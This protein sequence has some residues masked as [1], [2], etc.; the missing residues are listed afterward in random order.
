MPGVNLDFNGNPFLSPE[1]TNKE[2]LEVEKVQLWRDLKPG[3]KTQ[4]GDR[5]LTIRRQWETIKGVFTIDP[6]NLFA[7]RPEPTDW[8]ARA[9]AAEYRIERNETEIEEL[10]E[11]LSASQAEAG[12]LRAAL[13]IHEGKR[14]PVQGYAPGI[15][16]DMHMEA[17]AAYCVK[18]SPQPALIDLE[19]RHCRGGFATSELD[20][21]TPGWRDEIKRRQDMARMALSP[22]EKGGGE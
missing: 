14:A 15:P 7:Q 3:E 13:E 19:G 20:M 10:K 16:W 18:Y 17:Y 6:S 9:L 4:P 22:A 1:P 11:Q 8:Q 5:M 2:S 12:R 21:L